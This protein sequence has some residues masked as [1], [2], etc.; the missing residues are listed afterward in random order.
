[1]NSSKGTRMRLIPLIGLV[2]ILCAPA[3][4]VAQ[5]DTTP[6]QQPE[7][8]PVQTENDTA[9]PV[10]APQAEQEQEEPAV[11]QPPHS[12]Q[13]IV[14]IMLGA[15][16]LLFIF[17]SRAKKKQQAQRQQMIS[18]LKKGDKVTTIGGI[19]G[20]VIET[21]DGEVVVKVDEQNN[22]RMRFVPSAI[23]HTGEPGLTE[24]KK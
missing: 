3:T 18:A 17:S 7:L 10:E 1:M 13:Y 6:Q 24:D 4:L 12:S 2:A 9:A 15:L 14:F 20:T 5:D 8:A 11:P 21:R 19:I 16:V 23:H 22:I